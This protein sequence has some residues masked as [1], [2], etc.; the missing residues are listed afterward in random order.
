MAEKKPTLLD[1]APQPDSA[2]VTNGKPADSPV[3]NGQPQALQTLPAPA[4]P[5]KVPVSL[6]MAPTSLDEGWRLAQLMAKSSLVPKS[7]Q[8]RP[9]DVLVAIELG[10]ELGLAPMQALQSIAVINGK[11]SMYGDGFLAIILASS[12]CTGHDEYFEVDGQRKDGLL[13]EDWKKD[14]TAAVCSFSRRGRRTPIIQ[15]FTVGMA[16][17]AGLLA[18]SGPWQEYPDRMLRM[19]ARSWA[20]RD[21]FPDLLRGIRTM[22]E[23]LDEPPD[24][25]PIVTQTIQPPKRK[26]ELAP[27][28]NTTQTEPA[29]AEREP[30]CDDD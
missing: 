21:G 18:K 30:G 29:G 11:P 19:R 14:S 13:A 22:E 17:K 9:A 5:S 7:F 6:G 26:S 2:P 23:A 25:E 4:V 10:M 1:Q 3:E 16:K 15:K 8:D 24:D 20:G 28:A 27:T 12:L